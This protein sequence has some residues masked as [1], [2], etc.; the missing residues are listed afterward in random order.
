MIKYIYLQYFLLFINLIATFYL[1]FFKDY[2]KKKGSNL[3]DK[4]DIS[5]ITEKIELVKNI[6]TKE[7]EIL[8]KDLHVVANKEI[9]NFNEE[10][11][12]ILNFFA[13]QTSWIESGIIHLNILEYNRENIINLTNKIQ[14]LRSS[15]AQCSTMLSH[16][17]LMVNSTK[18]VN[19]A[20]ALVLSSLEFSQWNHN[21]LRKLEVCLNTNKRFFDS[22]HIEFEKFKTSQLSEYFAKKEEESRNEM[23]ELRNL[24]LK[25]INQKYQ[26]TLKLKAEFTQTVKEYFNENRYL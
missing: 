19:D 5:E 7:S 16:L 2:L 25:E 6:F 23:H 22:F 8:K 9:R 14:E 18:L 17:V 11:N 12:A 3:A 24:Y 15:Y 20:G 21:I 10:R 4:E 13:A 1:I 26:S